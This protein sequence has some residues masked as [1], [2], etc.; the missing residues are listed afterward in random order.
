MNL[1]ES[2]RFNPI[3]CQINENVRKNIGLPSLHQNVKC[4]A[5]EAK[6]EVF[7]P[8][9]F[10]KKYFDVRMNYPFSNNGINKVAMVK[11]AL[12]LMSL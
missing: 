11:N 10:I 4:I 7:V 12:P 9:S 3:D 6:D 5:D 8:F 2:S 1:Q